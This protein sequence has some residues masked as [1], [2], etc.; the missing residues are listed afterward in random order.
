MMLV[1]A[2]ELTD[3]E[4]VRH[5]KKDRTAFA[6]L[7]HR[8]L[9]QVYRYF[10]ARTGNVQQ[11]EDLTTKTFIAMLE[12]LPRYRERG[13]FAGWLFTIAARRLADHFNCRRPTVALDDVADMPDPN[14]S[15][16]EHTERAD[17]RACLAQA[18]KTLS[19][20]RAQAVTL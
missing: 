15:P 20:D 19:P 6:S 18:L 4:L 3:A 5:A 1:P 9:M 10:Y 8:Y 12:G 17:Q 14:L 2:D 16:E 13:T 11:A 7:Y